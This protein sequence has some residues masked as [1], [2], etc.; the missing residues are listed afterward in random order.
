MDELRFS[1]ILSYAVFNNSKEQLLQ[2]IKKFD[3][4]HV[5]SGNPEVLSNGL[6]DSEL[7]SN[8]NS[9]NSVI[10]PDGLGVVIASKIVNR[11]VQEKIAGIELMDDI[12][13]MCND[14]GKGIYLLGAK[15]EVLDLAKT[16]LKTKYKDLNIVGSH[17]GY[18][19]MDN[20]EDIIN[21]IN[22]AK[23][24]AVFV[25]MGCPR[26]EKFINKYI[27]ELPVNV[28]MGVGGSF[29]II[30]GKLDRA[31][32]WMI[33]CGL[34]WLYRVSKE[35]YRIKRLG[36]IPIFLLKVIKYAYIKPE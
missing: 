5:I 17:N 14:E 35:P 29:D 26:Q 27:N 20:C 22:E 11:P 31:P 2:F 28:L 23:P 33:S 1:E 6:T 30:A 13:K 32:K 18:F 10:I 8:C 12:I 3:K 19:D 25:A 16:N 34:E 7:F 24:Y 36:V 9:E 4:V 21:D 15:E